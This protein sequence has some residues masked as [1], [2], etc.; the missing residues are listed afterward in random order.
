M[1]KQ[2]QTWDGTMLAAEEFCSRYPSF[3]SL[4]SDPI[5]RRQGIIDAESRSLAGSAG[6]TVEKKSDLATQ[7]KRAAVV[8]CRRYPGHF[9]SCLSDD[10]KDHVRKSYLFSARQEGN[11]AL[12][13]APDAIRADAEIVAVAVTNNGHGLENAAPYLRD[14]YD[15]VELAVGSGYGS[16]TALEHASERLQ[17]N[18]D[19]V[20]RACYNDHHAFAFA[21]VGLRGDARFVQELCDPSGGSRK[22]KTNGCII[23]YASWDVRSDLHTALAACT[24]SGMALEFV[25]DMLKDNREVVVAAISNSGASL[26]YASSRM[27]ND[28][29]VVVAACNEHTL[30]IEFASDAL[31]GDRGL[32]LGLCRINGVSLAY[33]SNELQSD[34][35]VVTAAVKSCNMALKWASE[36]LKRNK[37]IVLAACEGDGRALAFAAV[38]VRADK[39]FI[40]DIIAGGNPD[41]FEFA[42]DALRGDHEVAVL[43]AA[44]DTVNMMDNYKVPVITHATQELQDEYGDNRIIRVVERKVKTRTGFFGPFLCGIGVRREVQDHIP[45]KERCHLPMLDIGEEKPIQQI[46]AD[47]VGVPYGTEW[48]ITEMAERLLRPFLDIRKKEQ[49]K[50]PTRVHFVNNSLVWMDE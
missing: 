10:M 13:R 34:E 19:I 37:E 16:G 31:K 33:A 14:E 27:R 6:M 8:L 23:R 25:S 21:G 4:L 24:N 11:T 36:E 42:S 44:A 38:E 9:Y 29:E 49:G 12:V 45:F 32:M 28:R 41:A 22:S 35:E 39:R 43:A 3:R 5:Q 15:I 47:F 2:V 48:R 17:N 20:K 7:A 30:A 46:V 50:G 26:C 1:W 40:T 18:K